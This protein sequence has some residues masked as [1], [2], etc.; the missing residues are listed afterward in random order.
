LLPVNNRFL[1]DRL[2]T[3]VVMPKGFLIDRNIST[4]L[5]DCDRLL[6]ATLMMTGIVLS[7]HRINITMTVRQVKLII[8]LLPAYANVISRWH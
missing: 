4:W 3:S 2:P 5:P 8:I 7:E 6:N 1:D